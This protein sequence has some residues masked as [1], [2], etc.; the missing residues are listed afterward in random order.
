[1]GLPAGS[2]PL[3]SGHMGRLEASA[4]VMKQLADVLS[5]TPVSPDSV[6]DQLCEFHGTGRAA[7]QK[8]TA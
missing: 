7:T 5:L 6:C 3:E 8:G 2:Q 4:L 1:M